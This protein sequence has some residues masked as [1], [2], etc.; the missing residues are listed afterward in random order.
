MKSMPITNINLLVSDVSDPYWG[1]VFEGVHQAAQKLGLNITY[2]MENLPFEPSREEELALLEELKAQKLEVL[3]DSGTSKFVGMGLLEAGTALV[4]L[5]E[6]DYQHPRSISP[7]GLYAAAQMAGSYLTEILQG[8]GKVLVAGGFLRSSRFENGNSRVEGFKAAL[9]NFPHISIK[10]LPIGWFASD[11]IQ[12][13]PAYLDRDGEPYDAVFGLSDMLA[14]SVGETARAWGCLRPGAPVIGI[15][16]DPLALAAIASG[17]LT[18][19]VE[20]FPIQLGRDAVELAYCLANEQQVPEHFPYKLRLVTAENVNQVSAEK[21]ISLAE[22]PNRLI[23]FDRQQH[24]ERMRQLETSLEINQSV[25]AILDLHQLSQEIA[26]RIRTN[27]KYDQA[28]LYRWVEGE[29]VLITEIAEDRAA[30]KIQIYQMPL[31]GEILERDQLMA[32]TASQKTE[33]MTSGMPQ[34][35]VNSR[36]VLPIHFSGRI[37]HFLDLQSRHGIFHTRQELIGLQ[38]LADQFGIAIRNAEL[39]REALDARE[40]ALSAKAQAEKANNLK[41]RLLA[42]VSH[43]LRTPLKT[44]LDYSHSTLSLL[45]ASG[46]EPSQTFR[47]NL[48]IIQ[49]NGEHLVRLIN[50][51]LDLSRAEIDE[52][53]LSPI[54]INPRN[55][56]RDAFASIANSASV[57]QG[58]QWHIEIPEQLPVI[59][60]DPPRLRQILLNLLS[61]ANKFTKSG[62]ITLGVEIALPNFHI[63]V[64]DTGEGIP[65]NIQEHIFEPFITAETSNQR[66][67]GIGLGLTM[68]RRL[69]ALHGG[70]IFLES[71]AGQGSTFHICLPFPSLMGDNLLRKAINEDAEHVILVISHPSNLSPAL[72][73]FCSAHALKPICVTQTTDI[74]S[75]DITTPPIAIAWDVAHAH[76]HDWNIIQKLRTQ[77]QLGLLP[78]LMF[79]AKEPDKFADIQASVPEQKP[80][81]QL[82]LLKLI[83]S[84]Q[85]ETNLPTIL[86]VSDDSRPIEARQAS[87][88]TLLSEFNFVYLNDGTAA[89]EYLGTETPSL[90]ILDV[91]VLNTDQLMVLKFM[92][93]Q[94]GTAS[95]PV[96]I[97]SD[98][99]LSLDD[100]K[101]L[102]YDRAILVTKNI[103][104]PVET[105]LLI[106]RAHNKKDFLPAPTSELV[107]RSLSFIHQNFDHTFTLQEIAS[108]VG[109]SKSYFS[110][111][112]RTETGLPLWEYLNR[113]RVLKAKDY[114]RRSVLPVTEISMRVGFDDFSYFGRVFNKYCGCSPRAYRQKGQDA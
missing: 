75:L 23:D 42:N 62:S 45:N 86:M 67:A 26:D 2:I 8:K 64:R 7:T 111:I 33:T 92:R 81:F 49:E 89:I 97:M 10:H 12:A 84:Y 5:V 43:E 17:N 1:Q 36:L 103:L 114:L 53:D 3:I 69:V 37:T 14:I 44:I 57:K 51:L 21:L 31:F 100:V 113:Y 70:T 4:H 56:I 66:R 95:I 30:E 52:L 39:Y 65:G 19:S 48:N 104:T 71:Q 9:K 55:L 110:Q 73:D 28:Y 59:H 87:F 76:Q 77:Q 80:E 34:D 58:V 40:D 46:I 22:L 85:P 38:A 91:D 99:T 90:V 78:F 20:T 72:K 13:L 82:N 63:W 109:I 101:Q 106:R 47:G 11:A 16:G 29:K 27:Y 35:E 24:Q 88:T 105:A 25:G 60:A 112:F 15:N 54:A 107:K 41:T 102:D 74:N 50:D 83:Q 79:G 6:S 94:E 18:A 108:A 96:L 98:Q 32:T 68:T 93:S 61:N